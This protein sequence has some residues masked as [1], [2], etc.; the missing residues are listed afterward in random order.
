MSDNWRKVLYFVL[1][2]FLIGAAEVQ[3]VVAFRS[4]LHTPT[5]PPLF[6]HVNDR[7]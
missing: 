3:I 7:R 1:G 6:D 4:A 5:P 2:L